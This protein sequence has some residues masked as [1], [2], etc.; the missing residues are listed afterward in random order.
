MSFQSCKSVPSLSLA[1]ACETASTHAN[2]LHV[3][4]AT[5][6]RDCSGEQMLAS[7]MDDAKRAQLLLLSVLAVKQT[8]R[9]L[10]LSLAAMR[11]RLP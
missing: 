3:H 5:D 4:H 6:A 10:R 8:P 11:L 7:I 1:L 9:P 2:F